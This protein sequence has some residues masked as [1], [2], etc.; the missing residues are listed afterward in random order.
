MSTRAYQQKLVE[1]VVRLIVFCHRAEE[2]QQT[3]IGIRIPQL[4][5]PV[6]S[7]GPSFGQVGGQLAAMLA[8]PGRISLC[9]VRRTNLCT[10]A[11]AWTTN[12]IV[13]NPLL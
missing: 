9:P 7:K 13:L 5:D 4:L 8:T 6:D 3:P 2:S 1:A 12:L 10:L 11:S